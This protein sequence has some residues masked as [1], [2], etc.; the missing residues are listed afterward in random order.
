MQQNACWTWR[1]WFVI[2]VSFDEMSTV[3]TRRIGRLFQF[4]SDFQAKLDKFRRFHWR[5][6]KS[7]KNS[8]VRDVELGGEENEMSWHFVIWKYVIAEKE[9]IYAILW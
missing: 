9:V 6:G 5:T 7:T 8:A 3:C 4:L 2:G 1:I